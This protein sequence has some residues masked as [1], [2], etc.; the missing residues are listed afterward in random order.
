MSEAHTQRA[1]TSP[2]AT[3]VEHL[4]RGELA[5]QVTED[6]RPVFY[7]RLTAP[8]SGGPLSWRVSSGL[9]TVYSCTTV[10]RRDTSYNVSIIEL[11]E[12]F[13][14]MSRVEDVEP[15]EV[16]IGMRVLVQVNEGENEDDPYPVFVRTEE[17]K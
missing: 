10:H 16:K 4:R 13:R 9:G 8:G 7:P 2:R 6:E 15:A 5:Y 12:G 14:L 3:Y 11:D 1:E 17:K